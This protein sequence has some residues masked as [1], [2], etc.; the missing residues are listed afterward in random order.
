MGLGY[1]DTCIGKTNGARAIVAANGMRLTAAG[2]D[3]RTLER[4]NGWQLAEQAGDAHPS[5]GVGTCC[6]PGC[7]HRRLG[8]L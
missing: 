8:R 1:S 6:P 2:R 7:R 4:K 5:Y 3:P